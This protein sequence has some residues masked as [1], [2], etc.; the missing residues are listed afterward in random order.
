MFCSNCGQEVPEGAKRCPN[1]GREVDDFHQ[2]VSNVATE[3]FNEAEDQISSAILDIRDTVNNADQ[4]TTYGTPLKVD[5]GLL[6]V[7]LLSIITCGIYYYFYIYSL[8]KDVNVACEGDG[9]TTS[10]LAAFILLSIVTCGIYSMIWYYKLGNRLAT[11]AIRY[12]MTFQ[13]NGTT[14][15]M[16]R[17]FGSLLCGIGAFISENIII[18][19]A[20][21]I[22]AAYNREHGFMVI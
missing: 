3:V 7:V 10:G 21:A 4:G 19:N 12:G 1:C 11:N 2:K 22:C 15:L 17:L 6:A 14:V 18:K 16:W 5:R 9:D 20:N 13:E 8:T